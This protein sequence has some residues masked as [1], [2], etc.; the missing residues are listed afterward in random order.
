MGMAMAFFK[1]LF[2]NFHEGRDENFSQSNSCTSQILVKCIKIEPI[3]FV[4][5][6]EYLK[7]SV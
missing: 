6:M 2:W 3:C 7:S 5:R 1:V 4:I